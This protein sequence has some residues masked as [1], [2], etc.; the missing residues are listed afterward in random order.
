MHIKDEINKYADENKKPALIWLF[1]KYHMQ[2]QW[3][4]VAECEFDRYGKHSYQTNRIWKP[5]EEG[6]ILFNHYNKR[7]I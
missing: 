4:F 5:T 3:S 7:L 1:N 6:M 2:S